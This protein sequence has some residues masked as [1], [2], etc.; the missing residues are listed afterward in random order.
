MT[1]TVERAGLITAQLLAVAALLMAWQALIASGTLNSFSFGSSLATWDRLRQW[2]SDGTLL[3]NASTTVFEAATGWT[4]GIVIGTVVG[5]AVGL[6]SLLS[7]LTA[8]FFAFWTGFPRLAFFPFFTLLFGFTVGARI[9]SVVF[10]IVFLVITQTAVGVREVDRLLVAN[11]RFLGGGRLDLVRE[12]YLPASVAWIIS[13]ARFTV[14]FALHA[15]ILAEFI[16]ATRGIG[17]LTVL[18]QGQ[19]NVSMVWAAV[20]CVVVL[21]VLVD[22]TLVRIQSYLTRWMPR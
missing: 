12:V 21:A 2:L 4:I 8:P 10:V 7:R 15:A 1:R 3:A 5:M 18:G 11:T 13:S 9:V 19:L 16:G 6:S 17:Y 14:A 22:L 20:I